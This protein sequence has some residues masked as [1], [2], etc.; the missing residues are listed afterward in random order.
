FCVHAA[1]LPVGRAAPCAARSVD[2]AERAALRTV[3]AGGPWFAACGHVHRTFAVRAAHTGAAICGFRATLALQGEVP[4]ALVRPPCGPHGSGR[5]ASRRGAGTTD[6]GSSGA[7][8]AAS[9]AF[10]PTA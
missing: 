4:A 8:G 10:A 6:T 7:L 1:A 5:P 2:A 3:A 9:V